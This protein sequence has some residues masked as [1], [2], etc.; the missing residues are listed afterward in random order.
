[1][2]SYLHEDGFIAEHKKGDIRLAMFDQCI[3]DL[4]GRH[5]SLVQTDKGFGFDR[6]AIGISHHATFVHNRVCA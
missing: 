2:Q 4:I 1:M 3:C 5:V 6:I